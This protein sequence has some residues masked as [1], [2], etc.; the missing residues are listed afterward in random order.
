MPRYRFD[1]SIAVNDATGRTID[2]SANGMLF[3][4]EQKLTP[5]ERVAL[6]FPLEHS[7]PGARVTCDAEVVRV[8]PRGAV[9]GIAVTYEPIEINVPM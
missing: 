5:G 7:G 6:V 1:A 3:E 8:E 9:Y 2:V 4:T